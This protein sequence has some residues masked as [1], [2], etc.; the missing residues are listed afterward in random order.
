MRNTKGR[1]G[2]SGLVAL[3]A[4]LLTWVLKGESSPLADYFLF[5]VDLPNVWGVL[6]AIPFIAA[7]VISGNRGGG[8]VVLFTVLQFAQWFV[9]AFVLST[10]FSRTRHRGRKARPSRKTGRE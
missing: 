5:H 2:F 8:P 6:N 7:A 4:V 3:S 1:W 10:L 9:I